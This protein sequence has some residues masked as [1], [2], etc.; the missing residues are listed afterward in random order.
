MPPEWPD[1]F[2]RGSDEPARLFAGLNFTTDI[3][4]TADGGETWTV[5]DYAD[6]LTQEFVIDIG[7]SQQVFVS[8]SGGGASQ[9]LDGGNTWEVFNQGLPA[10]TNGNS[11][12]QDLQTQRLYLL[13]SFGPIGS[14]WWRESGASSW[15]K[16]TVAG[17]ELRSSGALHLSED[18]LLYVGSDGLW[19]RSV[20]TITSNEQGPCAP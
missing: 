7:N 1:C 14:L 11:L 10:E 16:Q 4:I 6:G 5:S 3:H 15:T 2:W 8:H 12:L 19:R 20:D 13:E 17:E 18:R 9:S